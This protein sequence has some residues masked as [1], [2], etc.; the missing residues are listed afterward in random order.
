MI[1]F[2]WL[3]AAP[4]LVIVALLALLAGM[5]RL[6]LGERDARVSEQTRF[7]SFVSAVAEKGRAAAERNKRI[8]EAH[9]QALAAVEKDYADRI[10][11]IRLNA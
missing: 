6:Y 3:K 10:P 9:Q 2:P 7:D 4:Y 8:E 11:E 5:T 1:A